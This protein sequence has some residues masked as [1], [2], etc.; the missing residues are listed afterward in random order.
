MI[1]FSPPYISKEMIDEVVDTLKSGWITT[2]PKTKLFEK[3]LAEYCNVPKVL[4]LNSATAGLELALRWFGLGPGDEV[5]LPAYTYSATANVVMHCGGKPVFADVKEDDFCIDVKEVEKKINERTKAIM[6]V[7][8]AGWPCDYESLMQCVESKKHLFKA[9][10]E[11]QEKLGRILVLSDAA[12]SF[13]SLYKGKPVGPFADITVFSFH[14]V[15]N[16]TTAEGGA[17][18]F[19]LPESFDAEQ[20]YRQL[21][22][23]SL[24]GQSKDA[25]AKLQPGNWRYDIV[26]PGYKYN[27]TDIAASLGLQY[28]KIYDKVLERRRVLFELYNSLL[29]NEIFIR[30]KGKSAERESSYHLYPLRIK[31]F[32][33]KKRDELIARMAASGISTNVHF[34][35]VPMM[36]FYQGAGYSISDYP[37]AFSLYANEITL[38][39]YY[40]LK[41]EE[42]KYICEELKKHVQEIR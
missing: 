37:V 12:H 41:D 36:S 6:P 31:G 20:V 33:E 17:M 24:H 1:P 25:L 34:V 11:N 13:G 3:K 35:P 16:L 39:L 18:A 7:D 30:P 9:K 32:D 5:I 21:S 14:A 4:C 26:E 40:Q 38:P 28:L 19:S 42:V 8:F 15:K 29:D 22:V 2:G 10:G 27:M 23:K